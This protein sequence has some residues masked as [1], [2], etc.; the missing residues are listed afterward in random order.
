MAVAAPV[1]V[2]NVSKRFRIYHEKN[3]SLKQTLLRR[4]RSRYEEFWALRD[5]SFEVV[6]GTA[7]GVIG[8]NGSGKSTLLKCIAGILRPNEGKIQVEG[9]LAALLELGAGFFG[10]Y[11]GRENIY[12]NGA[13]LGL[14]RRYIDG[15]LDEI[16]EFAD[17]PRFIDN[18]VKTYSSG[19]F[20]RLGFSVAV[21]LDPDVLLVD[22]I[23]AVGDEA[24]QRKSFD[25]I[26]QLKAQGK[27]L[28]VVSHALDLIKDISTRCLWLEAGSVKAHG[29]AATVID[30]YINRV[31][32]VET[33]K[34][35]QLGL[36]GRATPG[37]VSITG[38]TVYGRSGPAAVVETGDPLEVHIEYQADMPL[39]GV[40]FEV[41]MVR[42]D[43]VLAGSASTDDQA[44]AGMVLPQAGAAVM[45]VPSLALLDGL[46]RV[47]VCIRDVVNDHAYASLDQPVPFR[48]RS[49]DRSERGVALLGHE[50]KLPVQSRRS[51]SA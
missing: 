49:M 20:A 1:I 21:H 19:M 2:E 50:W 15:V 23:L 18:A 40:R 34:M 47:G 16:I 4:R 27:T 10:E 42:E 28:I 25:R 31:N 38:V 5:V 7:L 33:E 12:L 35:L 8:A 36:S 51:V 9:R 44:T 22:E 46:Y 3:T 30:Q 45:R 26:A 29:S 32:E 39:Q 37:T 13:L 48:V 11:S 17:L 14:S 24:F 43:G 6:P 41:E